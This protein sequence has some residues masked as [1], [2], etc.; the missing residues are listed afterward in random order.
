MN[1]ALWVVQVLLSLV[2][3]AVGGMKLFAYTKY[4]AMLEKNGSSGLTR[5]L[6]TFIGIAELAG[7]VGITLP[8]V[9]GVAPWLSAW[10]AVGLSVIML[11]AVGHHLRHREPP[12]AP[13]ILFALGVFVAL[14]RF[15]H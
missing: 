7:A 1:I 11:L 14:G 5:G 3:I 10:A 4:K 6:V 2:F 8:M 12:V 13:A 15:L 9:T